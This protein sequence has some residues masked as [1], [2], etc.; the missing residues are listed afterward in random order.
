MVEIVLKFHYRGQKSRRLASDTPQTY[1]TLTDIVV[2]QWPELAVETNIG[3]T[4]VDDVGDKC[5]FHRDAWE[6]SVE[7]ARRAVLG[8]MKSPTINIF[9][10]TETSSTTAISGGSPID[11]S[12]T[13]K[14][15]LKSTAS[16][17]APPIV[18][19]A[20][21]VAAKSA[22]AAAVND[23]A[24]V[25]RSAGSKAKVT[26]R[27]STSSEAEIVVVKDELPAE[28]RTRRSSR[29]AAQRG[30]SAIKKEGIEMF[31]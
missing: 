18:A 5:L 22:G 28:T 13:R 15:P 3:L 19:K 24:K 10:T 21:R 23:R 1:T 27:K 8:T 4:Y 26:N 9:I 16:Q 30:P 31:E 29:L 17:T 12:V 6:D 11:L 7:L 25:E 20:K 2:D 14:R